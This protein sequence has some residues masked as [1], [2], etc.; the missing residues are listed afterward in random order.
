MYLTQKD[1]NKNRKKSGHTTQNK[2]NKHGIEQDCFD[3]MVVK[4]IINGIQPLRTVED[5]SFK[6]FV[7]GKNFLK[8][9]ECRC[10]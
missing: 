5:E 10:L 8:L 3:R 4:F 9:I 7:L 1:E 6:D 2:G